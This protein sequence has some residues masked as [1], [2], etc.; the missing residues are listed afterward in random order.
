MY[1]LSVERVFEARHAVRMGDILETP[2]SH[3]W[4]A[5]IVVAGPEL[6]ADGLLCD[7]HMIEQSLEAVLAPLTGVDLN[8][9]AP[10]DTVNPSAEHIARH[11]A[12]RMVERLPESVIL[13]RV[14]V[15]EAPGCR[16]TYRTSTHD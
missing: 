5:E 15:T 3:Q 4:R 16:A 12:R 9:T 8:E 13:S 1:E 14:T 6:D 2:H 7:F 11:I 10:F